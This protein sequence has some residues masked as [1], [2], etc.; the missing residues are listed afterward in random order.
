MPIDNDNNLPVPI[1]GNNSA[2]IGTDIYTY[3]GI[4]AH[5]QVMKVAWGS[6]TTVTRAT[7]DTPL[8]VKVFGL[9]GELSR[10]SITG[11]VSG[12]GRF[13]VT[14][15]VSDPIYVTGGV[16]AN[17]Y[18]ITGATPVGITGS[19]SI[20]G[21]VGITGTVNV[22]G[23]RFLNSSTD[24]V[25]VTG[26]VGRSWNL[27]NADD[28]IRIYSHSGAT[29]IP[30]ALFTSGGTAIGVSGNALNVNI[31]GAG[32]SANVSIGTSVG[33]YND[34]GTILRV[35]GTANGTPIPISGS[36]S[37]DQGA[38]V[39][40]DPTK[41]VVVDAPVSASGIVYNS[42]FS[43]SPPAFNNLEKLLISQ[44]G[45]NNHTVATWLKFI[46]NSL[47]ESTNSVSAPATSLNGRLR[48]LMLGTQSL[49]VKQFKES[50]SAITQ[51]SISK[52]VF[53]KVV[54][55]SR[56]VLVQ[57]TSN[58]L[59]TSES[60]ILITSP[61]ELLRALTLSWGTFDDIVLQNTFT[62]NA[63]GQANATKLNGI[64]LQPGD[65]IILEIDA[66]AGFYPAIIETP[67]IVG[68]SQDDGCLKI[69]LI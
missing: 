48:D 20:L 1:D 5:A 30:A 27:T 52:N 59:S 32:I 46:W 28:N 47:G 57:N 65:S 3:S 7:N 62:L 41:T 63:T 23:G 24:S 13:S 43:S 53:K 58:I 11:S 39:S 12:I 40:L 8:P 14:N 61:S 15:T 16:R 34:T 22:T 64:I 60:A 29:I 6:D 50:F 9:T 56:R 4:T 10:L 66:S 54:T 67:G 44:N 36:V 42:S 19:V 49:A 35:Q 38:E 45:N 33:V 37:L 69:T 68:L 18:G 25:T 51:Q 2:Y 21:N 17:V 26:G 31:V 55:G